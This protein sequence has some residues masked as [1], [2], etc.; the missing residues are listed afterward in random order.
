M[1]GGIRLLP[2]GHDPGATDVGGERVGQVGIGLEVAEPAGR[3][4]GAPG[5]LR[6]SP[7]PGRTYPDL[8]LY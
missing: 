2:V 1:G 5:R 4:D 7:A 8:R 6:P 3:L